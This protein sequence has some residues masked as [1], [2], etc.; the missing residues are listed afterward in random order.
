MLNIMGVPETAAV[1]DELE[2]DPYFEAYQLHHEAAADLLMQYSR[3][4]ASLVVEHSQAAASATTEDYEVLTKKLGFVRT[5]VELHER[6]FVEWRLEQ[7]ESTV[8]PIEVRDFDMEDLPDQATVLRTLNTRDKADDDERLLRGNLEDWVNVARRFGVAVS[9]DNLTPQRDEQP[10][11][12][13]GD[14][15]V[16]FRPGTD[17]TLRVWRVR[18]VDF[19]AEAKL[20][21]RNRRRRLT[22][23]LSWP[24]RA[25]LESSRRGKAQSA[26]P[27]T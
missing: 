25:P 4:L 24:K 11:V 9:L 18:H 15:E 22:T 17:V 21:P 14:I 26:L 10:P 8:S 27:W 1:C 19:V 2:H 5:E 16:H 6:R 12:G 13:S 7:V 3:A 20:S 23:S